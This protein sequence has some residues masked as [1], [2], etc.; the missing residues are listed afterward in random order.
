MGFYTSGCTWAQCPW[1][2]GAG[3]CEGDGDGLRP[4]SG[5]RS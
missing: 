2:Q 1:Q 5:G 3:V 4:A